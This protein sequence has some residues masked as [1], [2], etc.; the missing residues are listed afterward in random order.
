MR[1][2]KQLCK[3]APIPVEVNGQIVDQGFYGIAAYQPDHYLSQGCLPTSLYSALI[4]Y[5][6]KQLETKFYSSKLSTIIGRSCIPFDVGWLL[7]NA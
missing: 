6:G 3:T 5:F 7:W 1:T 2:A 4:R